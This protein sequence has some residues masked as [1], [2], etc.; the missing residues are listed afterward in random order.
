MFLSGSRLPDYVIEIV[1]MMVVVPVVTM[2]MVMPVMMHAPD[3]QMLEAFSA[4]CESRGRS[5]KNSNDRQE[6]GE[7]RFVHGLAGWGLV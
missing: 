6:G 7:D 2:M 1:M 4:L 3:T 5:G